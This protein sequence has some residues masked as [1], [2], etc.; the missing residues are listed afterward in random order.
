MHRKRSTLL[1][2][3]TPPGTAPNHTHA[4]DFPFS[5]RRPPPITLK[6]SIP[7]SKERKESIIHSSFSDSEDDL[8]DE[9]ET[10]AEDENYDEL[11]SGSIYSVTTNDEIG[12]AE[13]ARMMQAKRISQ[14]VME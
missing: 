5:I 11:F 7:G 14:L 13:S 1:H 6:L 10:E 8:Y 4:E 9:D 2:P 12:L 3:S